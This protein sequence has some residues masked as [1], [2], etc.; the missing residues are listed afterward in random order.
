[1]ILLRDSA[2]LLIFYEPV[3]DSYFTLDLQTNMTVDMPR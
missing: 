3:P 2:M 1:M